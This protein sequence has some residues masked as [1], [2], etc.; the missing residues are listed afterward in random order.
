MQEIL[1]VLCGVAGVASAALIRRGMKS[2]RSALRSERN[3]LKRSV[4][5]LERDSSYAAERQELLPGYRT[6]LKKV[7]QAISDGGMMQNTDVAAPEGESDIESDVADTSEHAGPSGDG[8]STGKPGK[9]YTAAT[10]VATQEGHAPE[11]ATAVPE[12]PETKDQATVT[13]ERILETATAVPEEPEVVGEPGK[14]GTEVIPVADPAE[15]TPETATVT[16]MPESPKTKTDVPAPP[17]PG[18]DPDGDDSED[19]EKIKADILKTLN[20]LQRAED[21]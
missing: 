20:R 6:R 7:E 4:S 16:N 19:L 5:L 13:E 15:H 17:D 12:E 21:D 3:I 8:E 10:P 9:K 14:G 18:V 1:I 2:R 11:T